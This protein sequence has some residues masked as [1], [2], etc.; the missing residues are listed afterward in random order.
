[1]E[2][3]ATAEISRAQI[4]QWI[5]HP[6]GRLAEGGVYGGRKVTVELFK[7][8]LSEE[9]KKIRNGVGEA[10]FNSG[11]YAEARELL[12]KTDLTVTA[13]ALRTGYT[14]AAYF[15]R[16]FRKTTGTTPIE[17]RRAKSKNG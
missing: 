16:V 14:D 8:V 11:K 15:S 13:V 6:K 4:W 7:E 9:F 2:D 17:Y 3:A 1:M 10:K 5:R 12:E